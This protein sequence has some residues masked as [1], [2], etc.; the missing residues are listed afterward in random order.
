MFN[1]I[2]F[3]PPGSGKG[4]QAEK[5]IERYELI[6]LSTGNLLRSEIEAESPLGLEAKKFMDEGLLVPDEVVIGMI[7][8]KLDEHAD[9]NGFIFDGFPRTVEQAEALDNLLDFK[10]APISCVVALQVSNDELT[11]R[12]LKR[13][14]TSGRTDDT[15]EEKIRTR[16]IEYEN[17]TKPVAEYFK[18]QEKLVEV[19]GENSIDETFELLVQVLDQKA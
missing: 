4:T 8:A 18:V 19:F 5:L 10:G 9:A 17:K 6:H 11:S 13:G 3:G 12:L 2:I 14:E 16:I 1:I 7:G 15:S